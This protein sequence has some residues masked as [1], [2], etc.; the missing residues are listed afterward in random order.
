MFFMPTKI[1]KIFIFA[2]LKYKKNPAL[3]KILPLG[4]NDRMFCLYKINAYCPTY[5][6]QHAFARK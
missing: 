3:R 6:A 1:V 5:Q 2:L 4:G